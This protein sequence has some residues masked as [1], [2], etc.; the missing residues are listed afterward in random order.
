MGEGDAAHWLLRAQEVRALA[1]GMTEPS[2]RSVMLKVANDYEAMALRAYRLA[3]MERFQ[4]AVHEGPAREG[5]LSA[6]QGPC[7]G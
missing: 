4:K 7:D 1:R 5:L 3:E 2:I 6:A